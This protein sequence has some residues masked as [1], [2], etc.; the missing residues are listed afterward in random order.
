M[1]NH[2]QHKKLFIGFNW[3]MNPGII[4]QAQD[5]FQ[6]YNDL[7]ITPGFLPVVFTP[8]IYLHSI[9]KINFS[10]IDIGSQDISDKESGAYTGQISGQMLRDA[11]C[12]YCLIN[13][14]ESNKAYNLK[15]KSIRN[16][17]IQGIRN[18]I[19]PILCISFYKQ[20]TAK[21]DLESQLQNIFNLEVLNL[22]KLQNRIIYIALEPILNIGSGKA[23][24]CSDIDQYLEVI[25]NFMTSLE[26]VKQ[27]NYLTLYGGSVNASNIIEIG[28]CKLVDGFLLGGAS[29]D[30]Q[31]VTKIFNLLK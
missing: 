6:I 13:H 27:K 31:Q 22:V 18:N 15:P 17:L 7:N 10:D 3:K 25:T 12:N 30:P 5:L 2:D 23:L 29:I 4:K 14:S 26:L 1:N 19:I 21:V 16:K 28:K 9:Q 8:N 24:D 20:E 11:G